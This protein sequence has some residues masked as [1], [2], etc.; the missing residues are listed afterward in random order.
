MPSAVAQP[1]PCLLPLF[2]HHEARGK[3]P[4]NSQQRFLE[5]LN[6]PELRQ[7]LFKPAVHAKGFTQI[8]RG[9]ELGKFTYLDVLEARRALA[10]ARADEIEA[11]VSLRQAQ[12]EAESLIGGSF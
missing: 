5:R 1:G 10:E 11:L 4:R 3:I 7:A 8:R 2:L 6:P 12:A 9:Y